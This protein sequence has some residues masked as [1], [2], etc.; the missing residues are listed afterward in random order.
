MSLTSRASR[1][2]ILLPLFLIASAAF[3]TESRELA[4]LIAKE[5][6]ESFGNSTE[7]TVVARFRDPADPEPLG[8]WVY[9][10]G[11]LREAGMIS[12]TSAGADRAVAALPPSLPTYPWERQATP[13]VTVRSTGLAD[14]RAGALDVAARAPQRTWGWSRGGHDAY[15]LFRCGDPAR[16]AVA[17]PVRRP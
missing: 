14:S 2:V 12:S 5:S 8:V 9:Q 1:T 10:G 16:V 17:S 11:A 3:G 4:E 6:F 15:R 7:G 13:R